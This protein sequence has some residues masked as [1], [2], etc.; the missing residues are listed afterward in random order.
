M[1]A[2]RRFPVATSHIAFSVKD[3]FP[4]FL[5]SL[6]HGALFR[7]I[8]SLAPPD[9]IK[10]ERGSGTGER[11]KKGNHIKKEGGSGTGER[12]KKEKTSQEQEKEK[13]TK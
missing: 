12:N 13:K 10:G 9:H 8:Y 4:F 11:N 5:A 3:I 6:G 1:R 7:V 2:P